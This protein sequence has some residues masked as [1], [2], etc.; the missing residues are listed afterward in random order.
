MCLKQPTLYAKE[1]EIL[2]SLQY[3]VIKVM[4]FM[5]I[6]CF[7]SLLFLKMTKLQVSYECGFPVSD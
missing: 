2:R 5:S 7:I 4:N 1:N 3:N 6:S